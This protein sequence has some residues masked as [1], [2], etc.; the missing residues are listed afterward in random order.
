MNKRQIFVLMA[1]ILAVVLVA[2]AYFHNR[3]GTPS[4]DPSP[5]A[6]SAATG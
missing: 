2:Y 3:E 1:I 6:T 5:A 4:Q